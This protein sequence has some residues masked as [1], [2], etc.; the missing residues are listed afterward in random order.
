VV[1]GHG[2][3]AKIRAGYNTMKFAANSWLRVTCAGMGKAQGKRERMRKK[4]NRKIRDQETGGTARSYQSHSK[5]GA[6][7]TGVEQL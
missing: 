5:R 3:F 4:G 7:V 1:R 2:V 6:G